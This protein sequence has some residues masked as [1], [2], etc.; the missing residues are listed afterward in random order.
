MTTL[1]S[2]SNEPA[3]RPRVLDVDHS[4]WPVRVLIPFLFPPRVEAEISFVVP[5]HDTT[6]VPAVVRLVSLDVSEEAL[7]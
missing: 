4:S 7:S 3:E 1:F 6:R 5:R 2:D